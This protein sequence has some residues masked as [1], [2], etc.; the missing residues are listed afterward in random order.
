[1]QAG[2]CLSVLLWR[3]NC[4]LSTPEQT[5]PR[6]RESKARAAFEGSELK[7]GMGH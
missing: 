5:S 7:S 4:C 2:V 1:M 3:R 6:K